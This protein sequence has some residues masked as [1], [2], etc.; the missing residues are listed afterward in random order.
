MNHSPMSIAV[1]LCWATACL[2]AAGP[3]STPPKDLKY[4]CGPALGFDGFGDLDSNGRADVPVAFGPRAFGSPQ[5]L[6]LLE[7]P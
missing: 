6:F 5:N 7:A 4:D 2:A 1:T 3:Q